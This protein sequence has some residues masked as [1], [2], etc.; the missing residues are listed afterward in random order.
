MPRPAIAKELARLQSKQSAQK[1]SVNS[2]TS[3]KERLAAEHA[4]PDFERAG[5]EWEALQEEA[6]KGKKL[7]PDPDCDFFTDRQ[8]G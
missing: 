6:A 7:Y 4:G 2:K 5:K 1:N 3:S 8:D